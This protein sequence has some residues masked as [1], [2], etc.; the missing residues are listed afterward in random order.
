MHVTWISLVSLIQIVICPRMNG[1]CM[2][3]TYRRWKCIAKMCRQAVEHLSGYI[4]IWNS[5]MFTVGLLTTLIFNMCKLIILNMNST[6]LHLIKIFFKSR[7]NINLNNQWK[8]YSLTLKNKMLTVAL[9]FF[10]VAMCK[11]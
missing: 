6:I 7:A 9:F 3:D 10:I 5:L 4:Y 2:L 11:H 1:C 8:V